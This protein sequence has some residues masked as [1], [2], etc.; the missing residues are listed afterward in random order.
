M[1]VQA[2]HHTVSPVR[3]YT[4]DALLAEGFSLSAIRK[5]RRLGILPPANG[6]RGR[7]AYYDDRHIRIL[8]EIRRSRDEARSL[9]DLRDWARLSFPH[10]FRGDR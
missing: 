4:I 7:N 10:A 9:S 5:Y 3:T 2:H 8:R 1:P 6:G